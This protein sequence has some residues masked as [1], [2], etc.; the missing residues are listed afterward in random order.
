M[1]RQKRGGGGKD[2]GSY[3]PGSPREA[4]SFPRNDPLAVQPSPPLQA[5][6]RPLPKG[7]APGPASHAT[8][9]RSLS[10]HSSQQ[11]PLLV[12][13]RA[14]G[15]GR[16]SQRS[17]GP[18]LQL[19]PRRLAPRAGARLPTPLPTAAARSSKRT[20]EPSTQPRFWA[21]VR[22]SVCVCVSV[23]ARALVAGDPR[24]PRPRGAGGGR[25]L[26]PGP[27]LRGQLRTAFSSP[28]SWWESQERLTTL[29]HSTG[30]AGLPRR[31]SAAV[32]SEEEEEEGRGA[33]TP[34]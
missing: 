12:I 5:F 21:G 30:K 19:S 8:T 23:G 14:D 34:T 24:G 26:P 32:A 13:S 22:A 28:T 25:Q 18:M 11:W 29:V 7:A 4:R 2:S 9:H 31:A 16:D 20:R 27:S 6:H 3:G 15:C 33:P 17:P 10:P 1:S